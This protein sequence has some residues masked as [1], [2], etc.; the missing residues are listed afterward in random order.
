MKKIAVVGGGLF[1]VS[2]AVRLAQAGYSVD[3]FEKS[4]DILQAASG[5]NQYRIHRG[6]HYPRSS[7]TILSSLRT[8]EAFCKEFKD[9]IIE[10]SQ[11]Y[12]CIPKEGSYVTSEEYQVV[13]AKHG[14]DF[15][16]D[17]HDMFDHKHVA[18]SVRVKER[19]V[20]PD[21]LRALCWEKLKASGVNVLLNTEATKERLAPYEKIVIA[22]YA[23]TNTILEHLAPEAQQDY[24]FKIAEKPVLRLPELLRNKSIVVADGPFWCLDRFG[25]TGFYVMGNVVH[26]VHHQN[27]GK[28]PEVPEY[29]KMF[30]NQGIIKNPPHTHI[31]QFLKMAS[32]FVPELAHAEHVGSMFT[33]RTTLPHQEKTDRRPT[34]VT[35]VN[36][37]VITIFS[38]KLSNCVEAADTVLR[39][40]QESTIQEI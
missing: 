22:A 29:L 40:V 35:R 27:I 10:D 17:R 1:G 3:L 25:D 24:Q 23:H 11:H 8:E 37:C 38:G 7:D 34:L 13:C 32:R 18:L 6:Y 20:D 39:M 33:I 14:L 4:H 19:L 28:H 31:D 5:I 21:K 36:D 26:S 30:I 9:A 15:T 2:A 12:Y 16:E